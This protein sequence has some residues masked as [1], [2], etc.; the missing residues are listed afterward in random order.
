MGQLIISN[1][2]YNH[3]AKPYVVL[4]IALK[5]IYMTL[6]FQKIEGMFHGAAALPTDPA[7]NRSSSPA[8]SQA[9]MDTGTSSSSPYS[10]HGTQVCPL[11]LSRSLS[12]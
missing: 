5:Y 12:T 1:I 7:M 4:P 9:M 6:L 10:L 8:P 2:S 11:S 3:Y